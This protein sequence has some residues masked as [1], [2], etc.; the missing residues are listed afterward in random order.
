MP[1][2]LPVTRIL[3]KGQRC[4]EGWTPVEIKIGKKVRRVCVRGKVS[5]IREKPSLLLRVVSVL[6]QV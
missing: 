1:K 3:K 2:A 4:H 6:L 5:V